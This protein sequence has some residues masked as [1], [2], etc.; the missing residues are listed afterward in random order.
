MPTTTLPCCGY[1]TRKQ[2]LDSRRGTA[3]VAATIAADYSDFA[4]IQGLQV[5]G[6][7]YRISDGSER[8]AAGSYPENPNSPFYANSK[9]LPHVCERS[10]TEHNITDWS[11]CGLP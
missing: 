3:R 11:R 7:A 1:P 9:V 4:E 6:E 5:V 8:E 10:M 2:T